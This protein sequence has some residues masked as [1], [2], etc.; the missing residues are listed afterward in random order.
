MLRE[1]SAPVHTPIARKVKVIALLLSAWSKILTKKYLVSGRAM[2][3]SNLYM[4][5]KIQRCT[6]IR[7]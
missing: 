5:I 4:F 2:A 1:F 7:V 3:K 6:S